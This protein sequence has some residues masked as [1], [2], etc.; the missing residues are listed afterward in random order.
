MRHALPLA[1]L[2]AAAPPA[3]SQPAQL[4]ETTLAISE[5]A[6]VTRAPDELRVT[7]RVEARA[8][9]AAAAQEAVNRAMTA[10][11]DRA[12]AVSGVQVST[13]GYWTGRQEDQR[14]WQ[15][16]Q[17]LSLRGRE[18]APLLE[19]AGALQGAGLALNGMAWTLAPETARAA[20]EEA[21]RIAL[22]GL[23]RRAEA[24]AAQLGMQVAGIREVRLDAPY[25]PEMRP[26]VAMAASARAATPPVSVPE[27]Q[28]VSATVEAV[29]VLRP[30]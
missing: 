30:R 27:D 29:V 8:G 3:L 21:G 10:A 14:V 11:V 22:D 25:R 15:A 24:V 5:T 1:L 20:R 19:L 16:A 4:A 12:R 13:G 18:A 26:M 2:V 7:L 9:T 28:Q 17:T 23:R 6:E